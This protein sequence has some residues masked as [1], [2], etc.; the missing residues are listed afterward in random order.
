MFERVTDEEE[1]G[2]VGIGTLI[3]FIA[4]VLVAAIAAGVLINTAGLLQS[5]AVA[6]GEESTAQVSNVVQINTATGQVTE[7]PGQTYNF[8]EG[9]LFVLPGDEN[10]GVNDI[11]SDYDDPDV[12]GPDEDET[13]T[14]GDIHI[15]V[16]DNN[17]EVIQ[18]GENQDGDALE[19]V[20]G[21]VDFT[22]E[23]YLTGE[24]TITVEFEGEPDGV[25][26]EDDDT[27]ELRLNSD[28][29]EE[30]DELAFHIEP[31]GDEND[32]LDIRLDDGDSDALDD[33]VYD[34][35]REASIMVSLGPGANA[36]DLGAA[37]FEFV[38]DTTVR[39]Q[40]EELDD[41][42]I[43]NLEGDS[44]D[45]QVLE[46]DRNLQI[47]IDLSADNDGFNTI[48]SGDSAEFRITTADGSQTVEV[49]MAPSAI[50]DSAVSL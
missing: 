23:V 18:A 44:T 17:D 31:N 49:L 21:T 25:D 6:T 9:L 43:E 41:L 32:E 47:V 35:V 22:Q 38:G 4:M 30:N 40:A 24:T 34:E 8:E 26:E 33:G 39:G 12:W 14:E 46:G 20:L 42:E 7:D 11:D 48:D 28:L 50:T 1:R 36:V 2:Q 19:G 5:Q 13:I 10:V 3:V 45:N 15:T 29:G 37:T 27:I 16:E